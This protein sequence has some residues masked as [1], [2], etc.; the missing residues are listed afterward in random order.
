MTNDTALQLVPDVL[1]EHMSDSAS[2]SSW[3]A[4]HDNILRMY[5]H[6]LF[7]SWAFLICITLYPYPIQYCIALNWNIL[8]RKDICNGGCFQRSS[9]EMVWDLG[10]RPWPLWCSS[11]LRTWRS[12]CAFHTSTPGQPVEA[13]AC[14]FVWWISGGLQT[15]DRFE[16]C[17]CWSVWC[18][19]S[20]RMPFGSK[21]DSSKSTT[22]TSSCK[23]VYD[24]WSR[25]ILPAL[26]GRL[27]RIG[28]HIDFA[29][30]D[31]GGTIVFR[32]PG[33]NTEDILGKPFGQ[34]HTCCGFTCLCWST[35][36]HHS[37]IDQ[38]GWI[39][40]QWRDFLE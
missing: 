8:L 19:A 2:A 12:S 29:S 7:L 36:F 6:W 16:G 24:R 39:W 21:V 38:D 4:R 9:K 5:V 13:V 30:N 14:C 35:W 32:D 37:K 20:E 1:G 10:F 11:F 26:L 23:G 34:E 17:E 18:N 28:F 3:S 22:C 33:G 27:E 40:G 31:H 15:W 25:E